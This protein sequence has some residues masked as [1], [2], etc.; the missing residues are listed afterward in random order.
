MILHKENGPGAWAPV[1]AHEAHKS[2]VNSVAWA[3]Y[4]LGLALACGSS[5]GTLSVLTHTAGGEWAVQTL[6]DAPTGVNAVS[7][8]PAHHLGA[9]VVSSTP[10]S[11]VAHSGPQVVRRLASAGCDGMVRV[12]RADMSGVWSVE[13][14]LAGSAGWVRDVAW[15]PAAGSPVNVIAAAYEEKKV[16]IWR[17]TA[18]EGEWQRVD[19]P[20]FP[21]AVWRVSW[22]LTGALLAVSCGD[23][24]VTLWAEGNDGQWRQTSE[25]RDE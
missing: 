13:A 18:P 17:Q 19:L 6:H 1:Y 12:W 15:A 7:W 5:D 9:Q 21:A 25:V 20:A 4:E 8:A 11:A 10:G 23:N 22:S 24:S 16:I 14:K 2:S 3:P